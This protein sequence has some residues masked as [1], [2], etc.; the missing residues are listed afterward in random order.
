MV[1]CVGDGC[2][3]CT[4]GIGSQARYVFSVVE[5]ESRRVGLLEL[6]R[7]HALR[8]QDW[9]TSNGGLRGM[10]IELERS[11]LPKQSRVDIRLVEEAVPLFF[12]HL[13]GPDLARAVRSTWQRQVRITLDE[14]EAAPSS[15]ASVA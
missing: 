6:G 10:T 15:K 5:W 2:P 14:T 1:P 4:T 13:E 3:L 7:G 11:S 9:M 12:E 8:V